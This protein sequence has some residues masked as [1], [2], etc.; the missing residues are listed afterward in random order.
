MEES[1]SGDEEELAGSKL[2]THAHW[3]SV[4]ELELRNLEQHGDE[5]ENWCAGRPSRR[6][7]AGRAADLAASADL[8]KAPLRAQVRGGRARQ[9]GRLDRRAAALARLGRRRVRRAAPAAAAGSR[10]AAACAGR[11]RHL[12]PRRACQPGAPEQLRILDVGTGNG[13]L[14]LELARCGCAPRPAAL[15]SALSRLKG[16]RPV[17]ARQGRPLTL[18]PILAL[19][20][21]APDRLGLQRRGRAAG[22]GRGGAARRARHRLAPG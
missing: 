14:L 22:G 10:R 18:N 4:Y 15:P 21:R 7:T 9:D 20:V 2:G 3:E 6:R 1:S 12:R 17:G 16:L 19:Q 5:G 8:S 11:Q 13:V